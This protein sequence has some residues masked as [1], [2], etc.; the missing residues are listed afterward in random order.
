MAETTE[1]GNDIKIFTR[2][3]LSALIIEKHNKFLAE[4]KDEFLRVKGEDQMK[5]YAKGR[6]VVMHDKEDIV[7]YWAESLEHEKNELLDKKRQILNAPKDIEKIEHEIAMKENLALSM[8][9]DRKRQIEWEIE[10]LRSEIEELKK[11]MES[12]VSEI[13]SIISGLD[14]GIH[15][16]LYEAEESLREMEEM[17]KLSVKPLT[18]NY[19]YEWLEQ[20]VKSHEDALEFWVDKHKTYKS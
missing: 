16:Y 1:S 2:E 8:D 13:D 11:L 9:E 17:Q 5:N 20:R 3:E 19:R 10:K 6:A 15:R 4:Y 7:R 18:S 14:E 12:N